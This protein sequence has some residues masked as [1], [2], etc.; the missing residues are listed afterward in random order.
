MPEQVSLYCML[1]NSLIHM[2]KLRQNI[3][4]VLLKVVKM[5][6]NVFPYFAV[7]FSCEKVRDVEE[8]VYF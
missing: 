1:R 3:C 7:T 4:I 5:L 2:D 8:A 6:V